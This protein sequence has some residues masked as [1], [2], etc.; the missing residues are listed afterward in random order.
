M[1]MM[2]E[3]KVAA[4]RLSRREKY[5]LYRWLGDSPDVASERLK[6][7]RHDIANGMKDADHGRVSRLDAGEIIAEGRSRLAKRKRSG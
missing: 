7:L 1:K 3:V 2:E 6:A 4:A 5:A